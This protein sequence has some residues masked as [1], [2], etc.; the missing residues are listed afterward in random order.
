MPLTRTTDSGRIG[1]DSLGVRRQPVSTAG[2]FEPPTVAVV[3]PG[4]WR[5]VPA[6]HVTQP[7]I[8][9]P[10]ALMAANLCLPE[11]VHV[12]DERQLPVKEVR[13]LC[14]DRRDRGLLI[15]RHGAVTPAELLE[16]GV[17]AF[18]NVVWHAE[19]A[20]VE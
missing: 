19:G 13:L 7:D 12:A 18:A 20:V 15:D 8:Q 14:E 2:G 17:V 1:I 5:H 10:H 16:P 3:G 4:R 6:A 9:A 11:E